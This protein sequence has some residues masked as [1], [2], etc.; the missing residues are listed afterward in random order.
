M[1]KI[2]LGLLVTIEFSSSSLAAT[3]PLPRNGSLYIV[4][5]RGAHQ[6]IPENTLAAYQ[7]AIDLG[8]DFVE[9][10]LRTTLD[11]EIVSIH[12]STVD[13]YCIDGTT[14]EVSEFTLKELQALDIGSRIGAEWKDEQIPSL[15]EILSI[16]QNKIGLYIDLKRAEIEPVVAL[17]REFDMADH[18]LWY[19]SFE[20]LDR[21]GEICPECIPMPD[22]GPEEELE[23]CLAELN[24]KVLAPVYRSYSKGF[25]DRIHE[26]DAIVIIDD[27][28][29]ESWD[30]ILELGFDGIQTDFPEE[31]MKHLKEWKRKE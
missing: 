25:I 13:A 22:P 21:L 10:D 29:K 20:E 2:F 9:V 11:G 4:A 27:R 1:R 14:G 8:C 19:A 6:G 15:R 26:V 23:K 18:A 7:R 12:N 17:L 3:L 5:H 30:S 24:P 31:L 28:G 16:C